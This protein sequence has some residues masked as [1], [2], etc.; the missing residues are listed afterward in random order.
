MKIAITQANYIPWYAYFH[1]ISKVDIF[2][3]LD[4]VKYGERSFNNRNFFT[5]NAKKIWITKSLKKEDKKKTLKE[6]SFDSAKDKINLF[7]NSENFSKNRKLKVKLI[8]EILNSKTT[9][10]VDNNLFIIRKIC[11]LF[12]IKH[13]IIK[14]SDTSNYLNFNSTSELIKELITS[15]NTSEFYNFQKGID[16]RLPPYNEENFFRKKNIKLFK[17][18]VS[19]ILDSENKNIKETILV[20]ICHLLDRQIKDS[21]INFKHEFESLSKNIDYKLIY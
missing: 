10:L 4:T 13:K 16:E 9:N 2:F 15:N 21:K 6:I 14:V 1:L 7:Y 20:L 18:D 11:K 5:S 3:I 17:Q 12:E 8:S 19:K